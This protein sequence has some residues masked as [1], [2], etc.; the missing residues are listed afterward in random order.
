MENAVQARN[1]ADAL[2]KAI[3]KQKYEL[4]LGTLALVIEKYG[5]YI[6]EGSGSAA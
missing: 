4:F 2:E 5:K 1:N 6:L 3:R